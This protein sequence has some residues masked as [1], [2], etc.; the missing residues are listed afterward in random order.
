M[1]P[2]FANIVAIAAVGF[3]VLRRGRDH[4][5]GSTTSAHWLRIAGLILLG[6]QAAVLLLF[7]AG[8]M[9]SGNL[10]GAG[11]LSQLAV[12]ALLDTC[13]DATARGTGRPFHCRLHCLG[14]GH[15][16]F[17]NQHLTDNLLVD[18]LDITGM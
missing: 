4:R 17:R 16:L 12:T 3:L 2:F 10:G 9:A 8:E 15:P 18:A 5:T 13:L 6:L 7:G 11:H 14:S 1:I